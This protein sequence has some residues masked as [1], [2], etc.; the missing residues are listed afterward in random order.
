MIRRL[1]TDPV[2]VVV[3]IPTHGRPTL[4]GRTLDAVIRCK[5]PPSYLGC[6]VVENGPKAGAEALVSTLAEAHPDAPLRYLYHPQANKSAALN[7]VLERI[8]DGTLCI[9]L[10]DDVRFNE[11]LL[12]C[13]ANAAI[14]MSGGAY[15]GGPV[16]CDYERMPPSW[17]LSLLSHSARGYSLKDRGTMSDEY[18]GFNWAAF[19]HDLRSIDGFDPAIG[20]GSST[21]CT[22]DESDVQRRLRTR[23]VL[24]VDVE[25]ARVWHYVPHARSTVTWLIKRRVDMGRVRGYF[26]SD[27]PTRGSATISLLK[28]SFSL[29]KQTLLL[30]RKGIVAAASGTAYSLGMVLSL[31]KQKP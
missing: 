24:P 12:E 4:L 30:N 20:P 26:S 11:S 1:S 27:R 16:S 18:L 29:A 14:H 23:G 19:S 25:G 15:F 6:V 22:G 5:H 21:G 2:A 8:P 31:W 13:Y 10:D 9:F 7:A 17:L 3:V 28:A